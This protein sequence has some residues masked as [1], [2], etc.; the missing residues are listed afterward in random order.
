MHV[1]K[2]GSRR[3]CGRIPLSAIPRVD[4]VLDRDGAGE[5]WTASPG[6]K[7]LTRHRRDGACRA[8][9]QDL[10]PDP[11]HLWSS[12]ATAV[13]ILSCEQADI[14]LTK[15]KGVFFVGAIGGYLSVAV[16]NIVDE[17]GSIGRRQAICPRDATHRA[18]SGK[19]GA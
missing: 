15:L 4:V 17:V 2:R 5:T 1:P 16:Q 8:T 7:S 3:R 18:E 6:R 13:P 19:G 10:L 11:N 12:F 9:A 14:H